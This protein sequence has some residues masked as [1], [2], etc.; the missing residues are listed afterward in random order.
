MNQI[1]LTMMKTFATKLSDDDF[2]EYRKEVN[3]LIDNETQ[4]R[5]V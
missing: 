4:R 3:K 1:Y 2:K 5:G